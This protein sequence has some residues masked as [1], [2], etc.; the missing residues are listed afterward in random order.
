MR[1]ISLKHFIAVALVCFL[2]IGCSSNDSLDSDWSI[3]DEFSLDATATP[4]TVSDAGDGDAGAFVRNDGVSDWDIKSDTYS[5]SHTTTIPKI[6]W[7]TG[8]P[9]A[10]I[11]QLASAEQ[12]VLHS[13]AP[14]A[15]IW[16]YLCTLAGLER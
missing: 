8:A 10:S 13:Q 4:P 9:V 12:H 14:S 16:K 1:N 11:Y 7:C 6:G 2:P 3:D 5:N 15:A